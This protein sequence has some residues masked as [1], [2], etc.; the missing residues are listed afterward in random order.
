M[1]YPMIHKKQEDLKMNYYT[2]EIESI[3]FGDIRR[4]TVLA[5]S[6][7]KACDEAVV[8]CGERIVAVWRM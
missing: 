2:I 1:L 5:D 4:I 6:S 8:H 3:R 7:E